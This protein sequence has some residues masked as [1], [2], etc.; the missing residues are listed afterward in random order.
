[1]KRS[2]RTTACPMKLEKLKRE[3]AKP[4]MAAALVSSGIMSFQRVSIKV[5]TSTSQQKESFLHANK[6]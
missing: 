1:M 5:T 3:K 4:K 6:K 2:R